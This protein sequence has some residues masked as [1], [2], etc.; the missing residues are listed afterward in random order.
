[1]K[2]IALFGMAALGLATVGVPQA[3]A[4]PTLTVSVNGGTPNTLAVSNL[5]SYLG[6]GTYGSTPGSLDGFSWGGMLLI[7]VSNNFKLEL[8]SVNNGNSS[9]GTITFTAADTIS[10]PTAKSMQSSGGV[11]TYDA[12]SAQTVDFN[13]SVYSSTP[14]LLASQDSGLLDLNSPTNPATPNS[15]VAFNPVPPL[16]ANLASFSGNLNIVNTLALTINPATSL[17]GGL[18]TTS[19]IN[20]AVPT[21]EPATLALFAVG[22]LAL[23]AGT[24]RRKNRA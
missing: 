22:G 18:L 17:T 3:F 13:G 8:T 23:L 24:R 10:D 1:M 15:S 21:P 11:T 19:L 5:S 14:S 20:S 7:G 9:T 2:N 6:S 16:G 4:T 12:T